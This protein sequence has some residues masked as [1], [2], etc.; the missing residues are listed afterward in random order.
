MRSFIIWIIYNMNQ[1]ENSLIFPWHPFVKFPDFPLILFIFSKFPDFP[2]RFHKI[3]CF[4]WFSPV[5]GTCDFMT[6]PW[7]GIRSVVMVMAGGSLRRRLHITDF[8][9]V[10]LLSISPSLVSMET[11]GFSQD[12]HQL[13]IPG[14]AGNHQISTSG[15]PTGEGHEWER[16]A[17][18]T[19]TLP[20]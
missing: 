17:V 9:P 7:A 3:R 2:C 6:L 14:S 18:L 10:D 13:M 20:H 1:V 8:T 12:A 16:L 15:S 5:V 4:H 11:Y 19:Q